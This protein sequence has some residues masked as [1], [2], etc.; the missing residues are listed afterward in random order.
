MPG[1]KDS[2][3][4]AMPVADLQ[5]FETGMFSDV[6]V[7][8]KGKQWNLHKNILCTRSKWFKDA[9]QGKLDELKEGI[10]TL[11]LPEPDVAHAILYYLYTGGFPPGFGKDNNAISQSTRLFL[12]ADFFHLADAKRLSSQILGKI[13]SQFAA[14]IMTKYTAWNVCDH[15]NGFLNQNKLESFILAVKETQG[16]PMERFPRSLFCWLP[17]HTHFWVFHD[18]TFMAWA[19]INP[20]YMI[21]VFQY[22]ATTAAPE[23]CR[24][25]WMPFDQNTL[26]HSFDDHEGLVTALCQSCLDRR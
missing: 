6:T 7:K 8:C 22:A 9:L 5:L 20:E 3:E 13:V 25:C 14:E 15:P 24:Q 23:L 16:F 12:A 10:I 18:A 4:V 19:S 21:G 26:A 1:L 17:N 2:K 11:E